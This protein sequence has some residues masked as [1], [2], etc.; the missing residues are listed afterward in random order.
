MP[1]RLYYSFGKNYSNS[2]SAKAILKIFQNKI[3][4]VE[5]N[6]LYLLLLYY[7]SSLFESNYGKSIFLSLIIEVIFFAQNSTSS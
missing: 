6:V 3:R 2:Q 5:K 1:F 7:Y 4:I